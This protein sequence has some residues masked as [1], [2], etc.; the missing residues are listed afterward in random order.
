M[1][2]VD[3]PRTTFIEPKRARGQVK[4]HKLD[5][6]ELLKKIAQSSSLELKTLKEKRWKV[7]L[8]KLINFLD[9]EYKKDRQDQIQDLFYKVM[10]AAHDKPSIQGEL[11]EFISS[12]NLINCFNILS[13]L[14][15]RFTK[16]A[17]TIYSQ[18]NEIA[19]KFAELGFIFGYLGLMNAAIEGNNEA[20]LVLLTRIPESEIP[21]YP[22]RLTQH[23]L[24]NMEFET[25][26]KY[27]DFSPQIPANAIHLVLSNTDMEEDFILSIVKILV[28]KGASTLVDNS[29]GLKPLDLSIEY[30]LKKVTAFLASCPYDSQKISGHIAQAVQEND[31]KLVRL[32]APLVTDVVPLPQ[33]PTPDEAGMLR[34]SIDTL[35]ILG[36]NRVRWFKPPITPLSFIIENPIQKHDL[37][38]KKGSVNLVNG[39]LYLSPAASPLL[40]DV[41]SSD[42]QSLS[43]IHY[44]KGS[45]ANPSLYYFFLFKRIC[46]VWS[47]NISILH[48][49]ERQIITGKT[50]TQNMML[51]F[52]IQYLDLVKTTLNEPLLT[53]AYSSIKR[54]L[55]ETKTDMELFSALSASETSPILLTAG[56]NNHFTAVI[57]YKNF[58]VYCDR[59]GVAKTGGF[60]V[61]RV[62]DRGIIK[63][64][65][66]NDLLDHRQ[67]E[68]DHLSE[69]KLKVRWDLKL[70]QSFDM[71]FHKMG[72]CSHA[73]VDAALL[74]LLT[75]L[76]KKNKINSTWESSFA[77]VKPLYKQVT[78]GYRFYTAQDLIK[79]YE[80][81]KREPQ[82][83]HGEN[84]FYIMLLSVY[85][86]LKQNPQKLRPFTDQGPSLMDHLSHYL[87]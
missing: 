26:E 35:V 15:E 44:R 14:P 63:L 48:P 47:F 83:Q 20:F 80:Y 86:R 73:N 49:T 31:K 74:A 8:S 12:I 70:I 64:S 79:A 82:D 10:E 87:S 55:V 85:L 62:A 50:G 33:D 23:V 39:V 41:V 25:I 28:G 32:L 34:K 38:E 60:R 29:K 4:L 57:M 27:L 45:L 30:D 68:K 53:Q 13:P 69:E 72:N 5:D 81:Y 24:E 42:P 77:E 61:Y 18:G 11:D 1:N 21:Q 51:S 6:Y 16:L 46:H 17:E 71:I 78:A 58:V 7:I 54:A 19:I 67:T 2:R 36:R 75:L 59:G 66:L 65:D 76:N 56:Y 40:E 37:V 52:Y 9:Y 84:Y 43:L 3:D 22:V